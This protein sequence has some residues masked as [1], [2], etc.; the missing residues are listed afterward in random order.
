MAE[1]QQKPVKEGA[2]TNAILALV[3]GIIGFI[4]FPPLGIAAWILG[5]REKATIARGQSSEAGKGIATAGWILGIVDTVLL[6]IGILIAI[7][8]IALA[9]GGALNLKT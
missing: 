3:F 6:I 4:A 7:L 8:V 2:S 1:E 5:A 9:L